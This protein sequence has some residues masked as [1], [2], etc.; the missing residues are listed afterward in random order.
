MSG[1]EI[2][3]DE[4]KNVIYALGD[5]RVTKRSLLAESEASKGGTQQMMT[6]FPVKSSVFGCG[7]HTSLFLEK[8]IQ[9]SFFERAGRRK[10]TAALKREKVQ[11][12]KREKVNDV[13]LLFPFFT[14]LRID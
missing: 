14:Y 6:I 8:T 4:V 5:G 13:N 11:M 12:R 10:N 2:K 9:D 1:R 7:L 3:K